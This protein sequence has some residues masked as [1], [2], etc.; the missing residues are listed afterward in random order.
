[1]TQDFVVPSSAGHREGV[2]E[3]HARDACVLVVEDDFTIAEALLEALAEE[4]F[5]V[6]VRDD[7]QEALRFLRQIR[8]DLMLLDFGL[9]TMS[10]EEVLRA[11][12]SEVRLAGMPVVVCTAS[13]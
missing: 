12:R 13:R 11:V 7:G 2:A 8:P 5:R 1:M 6:I 10:G 9:P 4:G 3:R